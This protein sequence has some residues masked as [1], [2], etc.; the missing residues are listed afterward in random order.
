MHLELR[1]EEEKDIQRKAVFQQQLNDHYDDAKAARREYCVTQQ[2]AISNIN[3]LSIAVDAS[4]QDT[5]IYSPYFK[6]NLASGEPLNYDCLKTKKY[7]CQNSWIWQNC[8]SIISTA[9]IARCKF[10]H[11]N[12]LEVE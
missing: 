11:R 6:E 3:D 5:M 10:D 12:N 8:F 9:R 1:Y 4:G 2:K 7:V